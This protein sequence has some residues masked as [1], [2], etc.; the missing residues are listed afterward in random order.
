[1]STFSKLSTQLGNKMLPINE[2][3]VSTHPLSK[4]NGFPYPTYVNIT[5]NTA[6][7]WGA[8]AIFDVKENGLQ[9]EHTLQIV[10]SAVTG[11][12]A[13]K[14][15]PA[16]FFLRKCEWVSGNGNVIKN[17]LADETFVCQQIFGTDSERNEF[18]CAVG[19]YETPA[20]RVAAA[21]SQ[22][23]YF[24]KLRCPFEQ[25]GSFSILN[26]SHQ[27][28]LRV[29]FQPLENICSYTSQT[30]L[31]ATIVSCNLKTQLIRLPEPALLKMQH[32]LDSAGVLVHRMTETLN[33][34]F[35]CAAGTSSFQAVLS[36]L[37]GKCGLFWFVV[38]A[39]PI[40]DEGFFT[41]VPIANYSLTDSS[42]TSVVGVS[43]ISH[44]ENCLL[45]NKN[46]TEGNYLTRAY[47]ISDIDYNANVYMY[48]FDNDV[49]AFQKHAQM[50]NSRKFTGSDI[51]TINFN[52]TLVNPVI[53]DVYI[54]CDAA[55]LQT[56]SGLQRHMA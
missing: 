1:M 7:A 11:A 27:V 46:T 45:I 32:E 3:Q 51:L 4:Q 22:A 10:V 54:M 16:C 37:V 19:Q 52:A 55:I 35:T 44:K 40:V 34:S 20:L 53:I 31:N 41:Y 14:L 12:V 2:H 17:A 9:I 50:T 39:A 49:Y 36:G 26:P 18:G 29:E 43:S 42:G 6:P 8:Q 25:S 33:Q 56:K 38:R 13:P 30:A 23:T 28:S 5:P 21:A 24:V 47:G 48:P 15:V